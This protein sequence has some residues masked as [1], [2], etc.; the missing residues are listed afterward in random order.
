M[1]ATTSRKTLRLLPV[2][3]TGLATCK[4][5]WITNFNVLLFFLA[6]FFYRH[7]KPSPKEAAFVL[8]ELRC[9]FWSNEHFN[10]SQG[11]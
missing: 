2:Q 9:N 4:L 11:V 3:A 8:G 10:I 7:A 5:A 6:R 1:H